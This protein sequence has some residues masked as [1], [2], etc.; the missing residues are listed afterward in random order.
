MEEGGLGDAPECASLYN[1]AMGAELGDRHHE[2]TF[3]AW[4]DTF[5]GA[6]WSAWLVARAADGAALGFCVACGYGGGPAVIQMLAV[7]PGSQ[8]QG[9]GRDLLGQALSRCA[10]RGC[11]LAVAFARV[12]STRAQAFYARFGGLVGHGIQDRDYYGE[13]VHPVLFDARQGEGFAT[14]ALAALSGA[15]C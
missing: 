12:D 4:S 1:R 5:E 11:S 2:L 15:P 13:P 9:V 3:Q 6:S 14:R 10:S 7:E 8:G